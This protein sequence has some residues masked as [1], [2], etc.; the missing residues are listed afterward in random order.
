M[1]HLEKTQPQRAQEDSE[2]AVQETLVMLDEK[3][4]DE[5]VGAGWPLGL[6]GVQRAL[7]TLTKSPS[8]PGRL[9]SAPFHVSSPRSRS[10]IGSGNS[11]FISG[12]SRNES[13][14]SPVWPTSSPSPTH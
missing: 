1:D 11:S 12:H 13:R 4:L 7:R 10:D 3:Q 9:E 5:I 2:Q 6:P 14:S 8:A